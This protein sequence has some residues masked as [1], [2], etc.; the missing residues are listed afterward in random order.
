MPKQSAYTERIRNVAAEI[1]FVGY[2]PQQIEAFMR[3]EHG[4]LDGLSAPRF[5]DEVGI[6]CACIDADPAMAERVARSYG[7]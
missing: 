4:T 6:A 7:F 2:D 1:G 3:V 5:R